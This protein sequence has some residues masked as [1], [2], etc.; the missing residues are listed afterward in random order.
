MLNSF[1]VSSYSVPT[2]Q[3]V[4]S[5]KSGTVSTLPLN[6]LHKCWVPGIGRKCNTLVLNKCTSCLIRCAVALWKLNH[7]PSLIATSTLM[8]IRSKITG[9]TVKHSY[10]PSEIIQ[11]RGRET[12]LLTRLFPRSSQSEFLVHAQVGFQ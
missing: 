4:I 12:G 1:T 8:Y 3:T 2:H 9:W 7:S 10:G 11:P 5:L 6:V